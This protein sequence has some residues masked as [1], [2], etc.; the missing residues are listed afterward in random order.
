MDR[1]APATGSQRRLRLRRTLLP[2]AQVRRDDHEQHRLSVDTS[3]VRSADPAT[4]R[5]RFR[6]F[7]KTRW[8]LYGPA[9]VGVGRRWLR[10]RHLDDHRRSEEHTSELQSRLH[11]VCRLLLEKKKKNMTPTRW[12]NSQGL[13]S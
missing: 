9:R 10:D 1:A 4:D 7:W 13:I 8:A 2:A 5:R 6:F 3:A 12:L 11:L